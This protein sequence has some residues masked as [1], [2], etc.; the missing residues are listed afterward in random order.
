M[1]NVS[2]ANGSTKELRAQSSCD[3]LVRGRKIEKNEKLSTRRSSGEIPYGRRISVGAV[4]LITIRELLDGRKIA[5][6]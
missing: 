1:V 5:V 4:F 2:S 3:V 6:N